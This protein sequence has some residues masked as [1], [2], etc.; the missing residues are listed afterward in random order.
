MDF[1]QPTAFLLMGIQACGKTSF[2]HRHLSAAVHISL[3]VLRTRGR[4]AK[5]LDECLRGRRSFVVDNTNARR[6]D[7]RRY[8]APAKEGGF[9][10]EG[11]FFR[12]RVSEAIRRNEARPNA[13][14]PKA[15]LGTSARLELP[16]LAEGFDRLHFVSIGSD[17]KF[18]VEEWR[19][20]V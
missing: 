3:D 2:Y 16:R 15:I 7:R 5:V 12:S 20:E 6:E 9:L 10:I 19:D 13:L 1:A 14:P 4:E 17:G 8:I 11:F 18:L